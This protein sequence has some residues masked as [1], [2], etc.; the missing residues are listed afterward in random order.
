MMIEQD[1][2]TRISPE[3]ECDCVHPEAVNTARV[4]LARTGGMDEAAEMFAIL[5]DP[6]RVRVLTALR[7]GE[8]CVTDLAVATGVNR[9][10]VSHQLRV[11]R[12]HRLVDRRRVGKAVFYRIADHHV[13]ALLDM[14]CAHAVEDDEEDIEVSA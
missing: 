6:T 5:G 9:T 8:L 7:A 11:L 13:A 12:I 4:T 10:T 3:D 14:A 2:E 1:I